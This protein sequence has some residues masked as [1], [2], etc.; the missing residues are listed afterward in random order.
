M[1]AVSNVYGHGFGGEQVKAL[2]RAGF[3]LRPQVS[4]YPGAQLCRFIDFEDGPS[5][6][7]IEVEDDKAYLD[8]VP[9]GM[10]PYGPGINLV[11]PDWA[12]RELDDFDRRHAMFGPYR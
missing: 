11:V 10:K 12:E 5:L 4:R 3:V 2:E 6:E 1:L 8:F 7:L 9:Q